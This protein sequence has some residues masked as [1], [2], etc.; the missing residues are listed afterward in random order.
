MAQKLPSSSEM[1]APICTPFSSWDGLEEEELADI[2]SAIRDIENVKSDIATKQKMKKSTKVQEKKLHEEV[3]KL[4]TVSRDWS[5]RPRPTT[6]QQG[7]LV[8][9]DQDRTRYRKI[10]ALVQEALKNP[11]FA[12]GPDFVPQV[13]ALC[14]V[15]EEIGATDAYEIEEPEEPAY[16]DGSS[17]DGS[18][19]DEEKRIRERGGLS[20]VFLF[21]VS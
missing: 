9:S 20:E 13:R 15:G 6:H 7:S 5:R 19:Q 21:I 17:E 18:V 1:E 4:L 16:D 2:K 11:N 14:R 12:F 10:Y 8:L 3:L